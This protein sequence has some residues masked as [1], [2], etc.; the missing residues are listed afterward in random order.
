MRKLNACNTIVGLLICTGSFSQSVSLSF[1]LLPVFCRSTTATAVPMLGWIGS[2]FG[3]GRV[4]I[5]LT[6]T[7]NVI[8]WFADCA[9]FSHKCNQNAYQIIKCT[10][11][12]C[13]DRLTNTLFQIHL[14]I[15]TLL[16]EITATLP[17]LPINTR[18][19]MRC[20]FLFLIFQYYLLSL[21]VKLSSA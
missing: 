20:I 15:I 1:S 17:E 2:Q 4:A 11:N 8:K 18:V 19:F 12:S 6:S 7:Q 13:F 16:K 3:S 9:L 10:P 21:I 5:H 14:L